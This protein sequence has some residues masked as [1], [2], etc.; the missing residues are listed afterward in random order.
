MLMVFGSALSLATFV[1]VLVVA[2]VSKLFF[3]DLQFRIMVYVWA[4]GVR[5]RV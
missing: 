4:L 1:L 5:F 2:Q 3:S